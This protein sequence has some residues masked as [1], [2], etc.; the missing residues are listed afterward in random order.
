MGVLYCK[1]PNDLY[2]RFSTVVDAVTHYNMDKNEL[3]ELLIH[4]LGD[5]DYDVIHFDEFLTRDYGFHVYP[6]DEVLER[7]TTA[8]QTMEGV[9]ETM[10]EMGFDDP[11]WFPFVW[12]DD[13]RQHIMEVWAKLFSTLT[14]EEVE[15]FLKKYDDGKFCFK[16]I[17]ENEKKYLVD[18]NEDMDNYGYKI[19]IKNENQHF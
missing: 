13:E 19:E 9:L 5:W 14:D 18:D 11:Y 3:K 16:I 6:F 12:E 7:Y 15:T 4:K 17:T 2:C 1:Q 10:R 8:N